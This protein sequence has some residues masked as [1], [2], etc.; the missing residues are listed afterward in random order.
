[1]KSFDI[2][3]TPSNVQQTPQEFDDTLW[4]NRKPHTYIMEE[5]MAVQTGLNVRDVEAAELELNIG[6]S[7]WKVF[8][9]TLVGIG[10]GVLLNYYPVSDQWAEWIGLPGTL[11]VYALE[12]VMVPMMFCSIV[13]CL[14]DMVDTGKAGSIC[15]RTFVIFLVLAFVSSFLG[16][17]FGFFFS[18]HF[19]TKA[20]AITV[21]TPVVF[22]FKCANGDYLAQAADGSMLC[23]AANATDTAKLTLVDSASYFSTESTALTELGVSDQIFDIL[24]LA[25]PSNIMASFADSSALSIIMFAIWFGFA[26]I[27][28]YDKTSQDENYLLLMIKQGNIIMR[29][30]INGIMGYS[31]FA[32]VSLIAGAMATSSGDSTDTLN[33]VGTLLI[34]LCVGYLVL[35]VVILGTVFYVVTRRNVLSFLGK[36]IPAQFFVIGC[37]SSF[38]T[39]PVTLRCVD[40]TKEISYALSRFVLPLATTSNMN[41]TALY[42]PIAC[43]FMAKA[44][45]YEHLLTVDRYFLLA[46]TSA[47][48][49]FGVAAV[50]SS[51]LVMTMTV[52]KAVFG[53]AVP[54]SFQLLVTTDWVLDRLRSLV[55][56]TNDTIVLRILAEQCHEKQYYVPEAQDLRPL[57]LYTPPPTILE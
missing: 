13:V 21:T 24:E 1:M 38:A 8:I 4:K 42:M 48:S 22:T 5:P 18:G 6:V 9:A 25:V 44:S 15:L 51:G 12:C 31:P 27:Q 34:A 43:I 19:H 20:S 40:S 23:S 49:S 53:V 29:M 10:L 14:S 57:E 45:G 17:L 32:I 37:S 39:L 2:S 52:W 36:M 3:L 56:V 55:N 30:L 26:A 46:L 50:P 28:S 33:D 47:I 7:V 16:A 35:T 54:G 41:G 11:F